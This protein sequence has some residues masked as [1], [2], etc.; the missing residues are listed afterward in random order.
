M[1]V[2]FAGQLDAGSSSLPTPCIT[3]KAE[4]CLEAGLDVLL[5]KP[6]VMNAT[7]STGPHPHQRSD[8]PLAR[9]GVS[10]GAFAQV[11][12]AARLIQSGS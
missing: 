5:E 8:Q 3:P 12:E 6:M 9:G 1:L 2:D 11:R 7:E 10:R 4:A